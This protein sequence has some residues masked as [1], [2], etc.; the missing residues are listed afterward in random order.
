MITIPL[1]S[2]ASNAHQ[3]FTMLLGGKTLEFI[4]NY[5]TVAGPAWSMDIYHKGTL[6][7]AG[8]MLEPGAEV[9]Q[10]YGADIG[11]RLVFIGADVTLDNLG[12]DNRLVWVPADE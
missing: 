1:L 4:I 9:S 12:R 11:G 10:N 7:I 3:R 2:G 5:I 6:L 8:A